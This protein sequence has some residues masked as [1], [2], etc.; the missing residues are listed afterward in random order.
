MWG[1]SRLEVKVCVSGCASS[2][3]SS[4]SCSQRTRPQLPCLVALRPVGCTKSCIT[5]IFMRVIHSLSV[6]I[7]K[8]LQALCLS[9][10]GRS[11]KHGMKME[12]AWLCAVMYMVLPATA[13]S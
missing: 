6:L 10:S 11:H 9:Q 1:G 3:K 8:L 2:L 12:S 7:G 13:S 4:Q 5:I